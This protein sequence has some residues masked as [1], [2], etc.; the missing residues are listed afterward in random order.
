MT[1]SK[2]S[3]SKKKGAVVTTTEVETHAERNDDDISSVIE[4][5]SMDEEDILFDDTHETTIRG[6]QQTDESY[7]E[8]DIA[9]DSDSSDTDSVALPFLT[10]KQM[11]DQATDVNMAVGCSKRVRKPNSRYKDFIPFDYNFRGI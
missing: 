10:N 8:P 4:Y 1:K 6:K 7:S 5:R 9:S 3:K 11:P 2:Q